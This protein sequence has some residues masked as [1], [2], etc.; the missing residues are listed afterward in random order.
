MAGVVR[1]RTILTLLG[2]NRRRVT[3]SSAEEDALHAGAGLGAGA[4]IQAT[5]QVISQSTLNDAERA[6]GHSGAVRLRQ[7]ELALVREYEADALGDPDPTWR[8]PEPRS[9][10]DSAAHLLLSDWL[11]LWLVRPVDLG[12]AF[13]LHMEDRSDGWTLRQITHLDEFVAVPHERPG[14]FSIGDLEEARHV[15]EALRA[16]P[17]GTPLGV[18]LT[19]THHALTQHIWEFR[20]AVLWMALEM[21]L[22]PNDAGEVT[23]TLATRAAVLLEDSLTARE[24]RAKAVRRLYGARSKIVHGKAFGSEDPT[25]VASLRDSESLLRDVLRRVLREP[26]LAA[27]FDGAGRDAFLERLVL[28]GTK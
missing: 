21:L 22:G 19:V 5:R 25:L 12:P 13:L 11:A 16:R 17:Y 6:L 18:A 3:A 10:Q 28:G 23:R 27:A 20:Y 7:S 8:G 15:A 9:V 4:S 2:A 26:S 14:V 1:W 24:G